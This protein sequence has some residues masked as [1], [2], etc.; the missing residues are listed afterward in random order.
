M[1]VTH[2]SLWPSN[3]SAPRIR[4]H[5]GI[6]TDKGEYTRLAISD[7]LAR[8]R[9]L[10][11]DVTGWCV[12]VSRLDDGEIVHVYEGRVTRVEKVAGMVGKR[13]VFRCQPGGVVA[14]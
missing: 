6:L 13:R 4:L 8:N 9:G 14:D 11:A 3:D 12:F 2:I 5:K 1:K 7:G 10:P